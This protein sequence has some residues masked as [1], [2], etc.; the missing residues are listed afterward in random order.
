MASYNYTHD[1]SLE[2]LNVTKAAYLAANPHI[3]RLMAGAM[4]FRSS[5]DAQLQTLLLCR[6]PGDS[7]PLKWEVAGGSVDATDRSVLDAVARELH[8]ETGLRARHMLGPVLAVRGADTE[9][10][11]Y[12]LTDDVRRGLGI[13]PEEERLDINGDG[14]SVTFLET[15]RVWGKAVVLVEV[16]STEGVVLRDEEHAAYKWVTED[17]VLAARFA[18]DEGGRLDF[19]SD[20]VRRGILEG[21][22]IYDATR[23]RSIK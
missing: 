13:G 11:R 3:D 14:L 19:V 2:G 21:F 22:S 9:S 5:P 15:G 16:Q 23:K 8:E 10:A 17:E 12:A 4:V 7:Y 18:G 6:S 1:T 20:G